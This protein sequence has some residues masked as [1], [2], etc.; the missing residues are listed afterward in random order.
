[1]TAEAPHPDAVFVAELR[2][3]REEI[4]DTLSTMAADDPE[5]AALCALAGELSYR[6]H[7]LTDD[8]PDDLH[9]AAQ[10]FELAFTSPGDD[11]DWAAW[12]IAFGHVRAFQYDDEPGAK[13]LDAA[14]ELLTDGMAALPSD[15]A[16]Y[17]VP[18]E[19]GRQLLAVCAKQRYLDC[20][21]PVPR[22][23]GLLDEALRRYA[24]AAEASEP[25]SE[26][27]VAAAET[28]GY[29]HMERSELLRDPADAAAA[30]AHYRAVL[31]A[32]LPTSDLPFVRYSLALALMVHGRARIDRDELESAR[33]EFGTALLQA[34]QATGEQPPWAWEAGIRS[35]LIRFLVWAHWKD[36]AQAAAAEVELSPLLA[37]PADV[38][39]LT[40][41]FLDSF[42]RLLYERA[43]ARGDSAG[44]DRAIALIRRAVDIWVPERDGTVTATALF[45]A[46]FQ[47]S[48]YRDD[49]DP[50]RLHDVT[51]ACALVLEDE[52]FS[53][54]LRRMAQVVGIWAW[55]TLEQT[56]GIT[57][58]SPEDIP[59]GMRTENARSAYVGM[60]G[61]LG[62]GQGSLDFSDTDE[63]FP[64]IFKGIGG[65]AAL[66]AEAFDLG[67]ERFKA[68]EEG[69]ERAFTALNL[70]SHGL[71]LDPHGTHVTEA[72]REELIDAVLSHRADD[73]SWQRKAHAV[74]AQVRLRE[75]LG[76]SGLG[77]DAVLDHLTQAEAA[78]AAGST[79]D[80]LGHSMDMLRFLAMTH[81]GQTVGAADDMESAGTLWRKLRDDPRLTPY[82]RRV[83]SAQQAGFDAQVAVQRG[84]L[85]TADDHIARMLTVH[86][87][88]DPDDSTRI[89]LWT[90]I[91]NARSARDRLADELGAPPAPP[92]PGRPSVA[93]LRRTARELPRDHRAWV[94][95][96]NGITRFLRARDA[97]GV[98]EAMELLQEAYD[99]VDEGSDSRLRY[100]H[101][102]GSG[103]CLL[104][105]LHPFPRPAPAI[106]P[107]ASPCWNRPSKPP[108]APST[109]STRPPGWPSAAHTAPGASCVATTRARAAAPTRRAA[110]P[111]LGGAA[112][113]RH[114]ACRA[115]R[116]AG[117]HDGL[118][119][120]RV[121]PA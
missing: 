103:H 58:P 29:L 119:G 7:L 23:A 47:Q 45:L 92:L 13:Y 40:P 35:A 72:Q 28:L 95:G 17:D 21:G 10:A 8:G 67:Y 91:E 16:D 26:D 51:R 20:D 90:L 114:R 82:H 11:P 113:V 63:D 4:L 52:G 97:A 77:M 59:E 30:A 33:E 80:G 65:G 117:H 71:L 64:G 43:S 75:Q 44:Q 81:R 9:L 70:L 5:A 49:P 118:G 34:Q 94:L 46:I 31:D 112:A 61:E 56:H 24:V 120:R 12:R 86:A 2:T 109:G 110:R 1:M 111:C 42:G 19:V 100:G 22:R 18:R 78:D 37:D 62:G 88:L 15:D 76:G 41:V 60:L 121:V 48:R 74:V 32:G 68:L 57:P 93:Q 25:G 55:T 69:D 115:G 14:W 84:D 101:C 102:L 96:D 38:E 89:E 116:G 83:L 79:D 3:R 108:A 50:L 66:G 99:L 106:S 53:G 104:A 98:T 54:S 39:R 6:L 87:D 85:A 73:P 105:Q 107:R 36:H 27:A